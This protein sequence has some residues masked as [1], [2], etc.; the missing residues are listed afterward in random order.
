MKLSAMIII[1]LTSLSL[2]LSP[3]DANAFLWLLS[4]EFPHKAD[5]VIINGKEFKLERKEFVSGGLKNYYFVEWKDASGKTQWTWTEQLNENG[6]LVALMSPTM[7]EV[8]T[9]ELDKNGVAQSVKVKTYWPAMKEVPAQTNINGDT[10][11]L[12]YI[13]VTAQRDGDGIVMKGSVDAF[14]YTKDGAKLFKNTQQL[15]TVRT[16]NS[17]RI[18]FD[19]YGLEG[20]LPWKWQEMRRE[21]DG[22]VIYEVCKWCE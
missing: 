8:Y 4:D 22:T 7:T 13:T 18:I 9:Y 19:G 15:R 10:Y 21:K 11:Y 20:S 3:Q 12:D 14:Y 6:R 5:K 2:L 17:L 16:L 1:L